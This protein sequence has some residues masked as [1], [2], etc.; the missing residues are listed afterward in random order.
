MWLA[1]A[2]IREAWLKHE[3]ETL[4]P[5]VRLAGGPA[6]VGPGDRRVTFPP[7]LVD[8]HEV[9]NQQYRYCVQALR[10][11]LP[12]EPYGDANFANG[13]RSLPVV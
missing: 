11:R 8:R 2:P 4:S 6:I 13:N 1:I 12:E 7:L 3:A 10:C 9:S 5:A